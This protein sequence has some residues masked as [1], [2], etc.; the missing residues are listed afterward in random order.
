MKEALG[1]SMTREIA[2]QKSFE[3]A[4]YAIEPYFSARKAAARPTHCSYFSLS[5]G[6]GDYRGA[7]NEGAQWN[8]VEGAE[9]F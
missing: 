6:R 3:K 4:L 8:H 7:W 2:H 5:S 1:F 9:A